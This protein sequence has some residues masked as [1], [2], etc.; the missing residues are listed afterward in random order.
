MQAY[1]HLH[2]KYND[3]P[4]AYKAS[5]KILCLPIAPSLKSSNIEFITSIIN[6]FFNKKI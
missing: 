6:K 5:K 2:L 3:F 4:N 1:K